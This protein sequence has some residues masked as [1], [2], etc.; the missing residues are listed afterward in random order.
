MDSMGLPLSFPEGNDGL[1]SDIQ[2][3]LLHLSPLH[4]TQTFQV[5]KMEVLTYINCM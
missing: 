5:P 1:R 2:M 4:V 3:F